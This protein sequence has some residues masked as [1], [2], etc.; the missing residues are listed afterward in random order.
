MSSTNDIIFSINDEKQVN[1]D[2]AKKAKA[3][4]A[5][6]KVKTPEKLKGHLADFVAEVES[7]NVTVRQAINL[8]NEKITLS[9]FDPDDWQKTRQIS[10]TVADAVRKVCVIG[11]VLFNAHMK[12]IDEG[13]RNHIFFVNLGQ[14]HTKAEKAWIELGDEVSKVKEAT[15][16]ALIAKYVTKGDR[17]AALY[18]EQALQAI[19]TVTKIVSGAIHAW[20]AFYRMMPRDNS[21]S[22]GTQ[23]KQETPQKFYSAVI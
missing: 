20:E 13:S 16:E 2:P 10:K 7:A 18:A 1:Q 3:T 9:V 12:D 15:S 6:M 22:T 8:I 14:L 4:T 5:S 17:E 11:K 19:D 21:V 23:I